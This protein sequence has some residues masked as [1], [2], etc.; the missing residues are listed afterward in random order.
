LSAL[1]EIN[2]AIDGSSYQFTTSSGLIYIVYFTE[3]FLLDIDGHDLQ[4]ISFG[5]TCNNPDAIKTYD[6]SVRDTIIH[7][8][9]EFFISQPNGALLYMCTGS[10][11]RSR[12][13]HITFGR[14]FH[15]TDSELEKHNFAAQDPESSFYSSII[16][17][18]SNP[19]KERIIE[20][21][22]HTIDYWGL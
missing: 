11:G 1:Y 5:F 12:N 6:N 18:I 7:I 20:A 9:K 8:I 3:F 13:R 14:W 21:F 19:E 2:G 17:N 10:D 15:E 4:V 16:L 22:Y